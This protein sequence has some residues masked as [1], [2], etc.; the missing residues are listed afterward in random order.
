MFNF[1]MDINKDKEIICHIQNLEL[2]SCQLVN[3][4]GTSLS[5]LDPITA[6]LEVFYPV[7]KMRVKERD[8]KG[9]LKQPQEDSSKTEYVDAYVL[10]V[11][12][13]LER[14]CIPLERYCIPL[15]RYCIP[16]ERY[17]IPLER[18]CIPLERYCIPLERYCIP[19][20]RYCTPLERYCTPLERYCTFVLLLMYVCSWSYLTSS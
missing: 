4:E 17:R 6:Q 16:L 20:E 12:I 7:E 10:Q 1:R 11:C 19:L 14:Y 5:I 15:E 13:P 2:F 8:E 9:C 18:Y 3:E